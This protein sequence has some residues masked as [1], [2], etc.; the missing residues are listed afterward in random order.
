MQSPEAVILFGPH[1]RAEVPISARLGAR[2]LSGQ[3][4]RLAITE[5]SVWLVDYKTGRQPP[6]S[7]DSIPESY[8]RQLAL[9]RAALAPL[10][11]GKIIK[12]VLLWTYGPIFM[13]V[14]PAQLDAFAPAP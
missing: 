2:V 8:L 13:P 6:A 12:P 3:I 9:Y 10:Y 1:S 4:D 11:P 14:N 7:A 5:D